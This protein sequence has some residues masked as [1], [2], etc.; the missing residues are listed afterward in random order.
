MEEKHIVT[1]DL[2]T[3]KLGVSVATVDAN[4]KVSL[5]YYNEFPSEGIKHSRV[6]N[7]SKLSSCLK[8]ALSRV[9]TAMN[10]KIT[11]VMVNVQR[12]GLREM[13]TR[14]SAT[15]SDGSNVTSGDLELL[16]DMVWK[17][18]EGVEMDEEIVACIPQ[19]YD[20]DN[21]EINVNPEDAVG[22][23]SSTVT[24]NF[25]VYCLKQSS[26]GVIDNA[27]RDS[28]IIN[29]RK[30]FAPD[31]VGCSI[32]SDNEMQGGVAL[33]DLGAGASTVSIF[34]GGVLKHFGGIPFGGMNITSD[35]A[36]LCSISESLAENIKMAY[37]G[38]MPDRLGALGDKKLQIV[39]N[40]DKSKREVAVKYLSEI[41]TARQ[42]EIIEALLYEIQIS[43]YADK[44]K[45]GVVVTGGAAAML[46]IC[47]FIKEL[48]GYTAKVAATSRERFQ[49]DD[50]TFFSLGA[51]MS[52]GLLREY[53]LAETAG[54]QIA[55]PE[56]E[57][58][59]APETQEP[60]EPETEKTAE[61]RSG[62]FFSNLFGGSDYSERTPAEKTE[63][64]PK[65]QRASKPKK[66]DKSEGDS[67]GL[68]WG[69]GEDE[70]V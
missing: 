1:I 67:N 44:L 54:C 36:N 3:E 38:C 57:I 19:S 59:A 2:G 43:G 30:V 8:D 35:I 4:R 31:A 48:S 20:M 66:E 13:D 25:K 53:S 46:N 56:P 18:R 33:I 16:S 60:E 29:V 63:K 21:G 42:K 34:Q 49:S 17:N 41:I 45:N 10:I 9:E 58:V 26:L 50:S 22:M 14:I 7:P 40:L 62:G 69:F 12:Y 27:F 37:G 65:T 52:G 15:T 70:E 6:S 32:L 28:G 11:E 68:L 39:N 24:G 64:K 55:E 51:C 47:Q 61:R 5:S 23:W